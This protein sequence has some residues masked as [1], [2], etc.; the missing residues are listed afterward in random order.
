M[1]ND[2]KSRA[3]LWGC[4]CGVGGGAALSL[5]G[6][7]L[8]KAV[9]TDDSPDLDR[10]NPSETESGDQPP[11]DLSNLEDSSNTTSL[12]DQS[13][14]LIQYIETS[15][16]D[17]I[18]ELFNKTIDRSN[19]FQTSYIEE[20][21]I[22]RLASIDPITTLDTIQ[23]MDAS[24][25]LKLLPV[26][27]SEWGSRNPEQAL[28]SAAEQSKHAQLLAVLAIVSSI[29][30]PLSSDIL[31]LSESLEIEGIVNQALT[32]VSARKLLQ[33]NPQAAFEMIFSDDVDDV[34]QQALLSDVIGTWMFEPDDEDFSLLFNSFR[35]EFSKIELS[36]DRTHL[37]FLNL[38]DQIVEIDPRRFWQLNLNNPSDLQNHINFYLVMAW[39]GL[40]PQAA[41]AA[42]SETE[43]SEFYEESYSMVWSM[44]T[45]VDPMYVIKN[46]QQVR[47]E[48]R[49][50]VIGESVLNL[51]RQDNVE[52][53]LSSINQMKDQGE[54][55]SL[56]VRFLA[57]TW[58]ER[59]AP[60]ATDWLV[61]TDT[62]NDTLRTDIMNTFLPALA[63][64]DPI[65]AYQLAAEYGDPDAFDPRFT[66]EMRVLDSIAKRGDFNRAREL[67][68]NVDESLLGT[69]YSTIAFSL[70]S[71]GKF[72]EVIALG[73]E[74]SDEDQTEY[75]DSI[76][77]QWYQ[78]KPVELFENLGNLPTAESQQAVARVLLNDRL[79]YKAE[80]SQDEISYLE[81]LVSDLE[82]P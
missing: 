72:D 9:A 29:S 30:V 37:F 58:V 57:D 10:T 40:D 6:L 45:K 3:F 65:R 64:T 46:I 36:R 76:T 67:L 12:I 14:T 71:Y 81:F 16:F 24:L 52:Q 2:M 26:V 32:E 51:V 25:R 68:P 19:N 53:A 75:F 70:I 61:A 13:K 59:D 48:V 18:F 23:S 21:L 31:E 15:T 55:V 22:E 34:H 50:T 4:I 5:V 77:V 41:L 28:K 43:G 39:G 27:Y 62:I 49:E 20:S 63:N 1:T 35:D 82:T 38:L 11:L 47:P 8:F 7:F 78:W 33:T 56:A 66:L 69:A 17:Q 74:L 54:N 73:K 42:I 44:W 60:A 80:M 79:G